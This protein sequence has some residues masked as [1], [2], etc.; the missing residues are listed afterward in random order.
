M[1]LMEMKKSLKFDSEIKAELKKA[2][3]CSNKCVTQDGATS[4]MLH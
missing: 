1:F 2:F 3:I 4:H